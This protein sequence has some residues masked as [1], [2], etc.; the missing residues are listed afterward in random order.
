MCVHFSLS[1]SGNIYKFKGPKKDLKQ[2]KARRVYVGSADE[3]PTEFFFMLKL[4]NIHA[5]TL[6]SQWQNL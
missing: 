2:N 4:L 5:C 1:D 6:Q 3:V